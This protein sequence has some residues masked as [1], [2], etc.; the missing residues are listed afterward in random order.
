MSR[1]YIKIPVNYISSLSYSLSTG[2][3]Q[4]IM[5]AIST[6]FRD[7]PD[8]DRSDEAYKIIDDYAET[9]PSAI[10]L[11]LIFDLLTEV[12]EVVNE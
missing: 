8:C 9:D 2:E 4:T 10:R 5:M 3:L 6:Y 12:I 7:L 1:N 11:N